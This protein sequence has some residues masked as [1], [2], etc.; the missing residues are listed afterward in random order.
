[1]N[2][3]LDDLAADGQVAVIDIDALAAEFGGEAHLPDGIHHSNLMQK[4]LRAELVRH[5][6]LG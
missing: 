1:M 3:M 5:L 4:A 6:A 2:V